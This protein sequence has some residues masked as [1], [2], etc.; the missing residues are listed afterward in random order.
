VVHTLRCFARNPQGLTF[1]LL[2]NV[3][4]E[5]DTRDVE[6]QCAEGRDKNNLHEGRSDGA[7]TRE[8]GRR[9]KYV[10]R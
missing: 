8:E 1:L 3:G 4:K 7:R 9:E 10:G 6:R 5:N 2:G